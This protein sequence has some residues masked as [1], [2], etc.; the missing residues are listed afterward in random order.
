MEEETHV[1]NDKM[2]TELK[3]AIV[4]I[5][6]CCTVLPAD[7]GQL[8]YIRVGE[9]ES[10]TRIVFEFGSTVKFKG[11]EIKSPG[12]ISVDFFD[13]TTD[14][15]ALQKM[16]DRSG[17]IEKIEFVQK[18]SVLTANISLTSSSF[19][20]KPFY[21]FTPDRFVLDIYWSSTPAASVTT[22]PPVREK[23]SD[24][25][26]AKPAPEDTVQT[27]DRPAVGIPP[28]TV[29]PVQEA[30]RQIQQ[31]SSDSSRLQ[32]YPFMVLIGFSVIAIGVV[33]FVTFILLRKRR[34]AGPLRGKVVTERE[35][36]IAD[37]QL[38]EESISILDSKIQ[39]E[40]NKYGR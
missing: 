6:F 8:K 1:I 24:T 3:L 14:N 2:K 29:T 36:R 30:E 20:L 40:L 19:N 35:A 13:T 22:I 25:V 15:P 23:M 9:Y 21:L 28:E 12:Q 39:D 11:P 17:R 32:S 27:T 37:D 10:L 31:T 16:R 38:D 26:A 7:A 4:L 33:L 34:L 18:K 5:I